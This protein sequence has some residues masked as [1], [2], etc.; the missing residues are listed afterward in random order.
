M[1]TKYNDMNVILA[2]NKL[3]VFFDGLVEDREWYVPPLL[4]GAV[5]HAMRRPN[6]PELIH[7]V[8]DKLEYGS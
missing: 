4:R 1:R 2:G 3:S 6:R 5:L 8:I 7:V